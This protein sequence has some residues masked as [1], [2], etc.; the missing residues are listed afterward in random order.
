MYFNCDLCGGQTEVLS[1][2]IY[3]YK[4]SGL[5]NVYLENI[6][7]R[8]CKQCKEKSAII[9]RIMQVHKL[10]ALAITLSDTPLNGKEVRFIRTELGYKIKDWAKLLKVSDATVV[11]WEK[12]SQAIGAQSDAL[13]RLCFIQTIQ[14]RNSQLFKESVIKRIASIKEGQ[15][16]NIFINATEPST[17]RYFNAA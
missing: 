6:E 17:Y 4:E 5:D 1:N 12:S 8:E 16:P 7:V 14:E 2:Q 11:C 9:P 15:K 3:H 13:I 10:M